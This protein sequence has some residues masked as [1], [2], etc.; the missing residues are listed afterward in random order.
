MQ[1]LDIKAAG[2]RLEGGGGGT[3]NEFQIGNYLQA[4]S[5]VSAGEME[6]KW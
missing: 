5:V 3:G 2:A 4:H 6:T 1:S